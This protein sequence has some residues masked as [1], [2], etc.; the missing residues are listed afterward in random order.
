MSRLREDRALAVI[1]ARS[2]RDPAGLARALAGAGMRIVEL[3]FTLEGVLDAIEA[4]AA[5]DAIVGAGTVVTAEQAEAA[6]ARG[7][8]FV[9][10]PAVVPEVAAVCR[11]ANVAAFLGAFTP[12]EVL[13][14][15][16][17]GAAA[18][19]IFP[20]SVGGPGYLRDL[21]GPFA[22]TPFLPSGGVTDENAGAFLAAGAVAISAGSSVAPPA[23]VQNGRHEEIAARAARLLAHLRSATREQ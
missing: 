20:A 5:T 3:T 13:A 8:R 4:A 15:R 10:S 7:A 22:G 14:A 1:R 17:A 6:I 9:V 19:K 11:R 21:L 18:V 23:L 2:V 12:T 16:E